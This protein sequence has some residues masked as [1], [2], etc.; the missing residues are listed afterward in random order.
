[1]TIIKERRGTAAALASA[2]PVL[3]EGQWCQ[4]K[5][6]GKVKLGNGTTAWLD[7]PYFIPEDQM[8]GKFVTVIDDDDVFDMKVLEFTDANR[9][10]PVSPSY[11]RYDWQGLGSTAPANM[12]DGDRWTQE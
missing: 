6:T 2:N 8:A 10:R 4:E 1:M 3:A 7:L 12:A 11:V 5:D 9:S